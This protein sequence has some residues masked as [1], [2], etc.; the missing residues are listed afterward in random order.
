MADM[1]SEASRNEMLSSYYLGFD[2][3]T[4]TLKALVIDDN[5][6]I[7]T[8]CV[9]DFDKD[10]PV[11]RTSGGAHSKGLEVTSP[12]L[13]WIEAVDLIMN[14]LTMAGLDFSRVRSIS[15]TGQQHGSVYWLSSSEKVL[16]SLN[17]E[18][19]LSSQ[20]KVGRPI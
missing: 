14:K 9:V 20:L 11:F 3:S 15:G 16:Q 17:S 6:T 18:K 8:E 4:Q 12:V 7:V 5:L 2:L 10:L 19:C 13:M 1:D